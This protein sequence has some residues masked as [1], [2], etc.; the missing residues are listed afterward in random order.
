MPPEA[1]VELERVA[2]GEAEKDQREWQPRGGGT[3]QRPSWR[4]RPKNLTKR[5]LRRRARR[6]L[7]DIPILERKPQAQGAPGE[8]RFVV[9]KS[10]WAQGNHPVFILSEED[11]KWIQE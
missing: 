8:E 2:S 1:L 7:A 10:F 11:K 6:L 5:L 3:P 4:H 9:R